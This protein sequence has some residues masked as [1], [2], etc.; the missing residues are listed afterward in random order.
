MKAWYFSTTEKKLRY[1]D[2]RKIKLGVTHEIEGKPVLCK[3]GLH[4]SVD[5]LDAL[6]YAPSNVVW[7]V[8]LD[9]SMDKGSDKIAAQKRT[10]LKGGIDISETLREFA[11][12]CALEVIDLWDAP[13]VVIQYLKTGDEKIRDAAMAAARAAAMAAAWD[14]VREKQSKKLEEMVMYI[15]GD[16]Q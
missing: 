8:N 16:K 11:R 3:K 1:G 15:I 5:I 2:N 10:Y 13:D 7:L 12:W 4:G 6:S 14:A 9:G